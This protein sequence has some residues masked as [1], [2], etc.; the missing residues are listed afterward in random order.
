MKLRAK[1]IAR[2]GKHPVL[3]TLEN[4]ADGEVPFSAYILTAPV[5]EAHMKQA[6]MATEYMLRAHAASKSREID[7]DELVATLDSAIEGAPTSI[8]VG[9]GFIVGWN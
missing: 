9:A 5:T 1:D 8:P 7:E 4:L 2:D 3:V 6:R